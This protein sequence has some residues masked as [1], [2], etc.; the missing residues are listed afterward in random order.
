MRIY[1]WIYYG[2]YRGLMK[3]AH[4]FHWHYAPPNPWLTNDAG[5][6][7]HW[8]KWCGMRDFVMPRRKL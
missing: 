7:L 1:N 4:R 2:C 6:P 3:L 5:W 8:C